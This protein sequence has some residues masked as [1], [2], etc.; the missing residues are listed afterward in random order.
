MNARRIAAFL[1]LRLASRPEVCLGWATVL[2]PDR[3]LKSSQVP[4][5]P[6]GFMGRRMDYE[7]GSG[8]Y[9]YLPLRPMRPLSQL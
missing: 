4:L 2:N 5:Q 8:L 3:T 1:R 9:Y 6:Y 7:E